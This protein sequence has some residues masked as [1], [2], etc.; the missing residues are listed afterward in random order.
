MADIILG[1]AD[2][3][4]FANVAETAE[5]EVAKTQGAARK[6][7]MISPH[8]EIALFRPEV[9]QSF[10]NVSMRIKGFETIGKENLEKALANFQGKYNLETDG[11]H[12]TL[13][14]PAD[15]VEASDGVAME[16]LKQCS[17]S[18]PIDEVWR[19]RGDMYAE[20]A[21]SVRELFKA[22]KEKAA[23]DIHLQPDEPPLIRI[24]NVLGR[25]DLT[26]KLTN[27]QIDKLLQQ[28]APA[29]EYERFLA[30]KQVSFRFHEVGLGYARCSA[31]LKHGAIHLTLRYLPEK[32]PSF[33]E[34]SLP[35][36]V[37]EHM[38]SEERGLFLVVGM[39]GCGKTT[40]LA[41]MVDFINENRKKHILTIESPV[42]Y[43]HANKKSVVSQRDTGLDVPDFQM[44]VTAA[45]RHDPDVIVIGEMMN[46]DTIRAAINAAATGHLVLSTLH[47]TTAAEVANRI[48]S[49]F[50]PVERDLVRLQLKD[51]LRGIVNQRLVPRIGGGRIPAIEVMIQDHK[52]IADGIIFG[53]SELI[54]VGMQQTTSRSF[55]IEKYVH[56]LY[57]EKKISL[58]D[59]RATA[60]D[61]SVLDQ[62]IIGTYTV[63]RVEGLKVEHGQMF[64]N[65]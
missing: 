24:D 13:T 38:A 57:K 44:G 50:E 15:G 21:L 17:S 60:T 6:I 49:F 12:A 39:T 41:S 25:T 29:D 32:I 27:V 34:L 22:M 9:D 54:H 58:E 16:F 52:Q 48:V 7:I 18:L 63:P 28:M 30:E 23:S 8:V 2:T 51:C 14:Y 42:E 10:A 31:F 26:G 35:R 46:A 62:M 64:S 47:S 36:D 55:I 5:H 61:V 33:E 4:S 19:V 65:R 56:R 20:Q 1:M 53:S 43:V 3:S 40:T 37:L 11:S 59:A 45:L